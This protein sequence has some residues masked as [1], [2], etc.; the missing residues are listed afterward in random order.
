MDTGSHEGRI[1]GTPETGKPQTAKKQRG[2]QVL[3][4][5]LYGLYVVAFL[6]IGTAIGFISKSPGLIYIVKGVFASEEPA[7]VFGRPALN[8]LILG[9]DEDRLPGGEQISRSSARSDM[10]MV[11][12]LNFEE[13]RITGLTIPRDT[14]A[15]TP[16]YDAMRINAFHAFGGP[17][18]AQ[19]AVEKL[20]GVRIDRVVVVNYGV[21]QE[22]VDLVGGIEV[23]V[24][25]RLKYDDERGNLHIDL[26]PGKQVLDGYKA[27]D[28]V[29]FRGDGDFRRQGRQ[30][31][32]LI[33]F[34]DRAIQRWTKLPELVERT[35]ELTG[36]VFDDRELASL[37]LF[38]RRVGSQ[39]IK[40]G[41]LPVLEGENYD[42]M[43][44]TEKL[45]D[46]LKEF[47]LIRT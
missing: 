33:A 35:R 32:F 8:L 15:E 34:K 41:M 17:N 18:L 30:R 22:M 11:V 29:R 19:T 44:D 40:L 2:K 27:M 16:G 38:S 12:R 36:N 25:K 4:W 3:H 23:D 43:V 14:L 26:H 21:F 31:S 46:T 13:D 7:E 45:Y 9:T 1:A 20:I 42:L 47:E 6:A 37:F 10:V 39:N 28:Y 24:K 5:S